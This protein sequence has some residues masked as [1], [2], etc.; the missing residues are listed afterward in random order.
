M[1]RITAKR[2]RGR[3]WEVRL[4]RAIVNL[5]AP[6]DHDVLIIRH[7]WQVEADCEVMAIRR[8]QERWEV[9]P[10]RKLLPRPDDG[11]WEYAVRCADK[12]DRKRAQANHV[13]QQSL[14]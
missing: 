12:R 1:A 6:E 5:D 7:R 11:D 9:D 13:R 8:A 4:A 10:E 3:R 2:K 14:W